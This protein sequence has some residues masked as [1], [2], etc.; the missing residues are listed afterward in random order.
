MKKLT[1]MPLAMGLL[2]LLSLGTV[3]YADEGGNGNCKMA[4][5]ATAKKI[6]SRW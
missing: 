3:A 1:T 4:T 5:V 2:A 6:I